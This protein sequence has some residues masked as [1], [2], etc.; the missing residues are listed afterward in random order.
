MNTS[1]PEMCLSRNIYPEF[2]TIWFMLAQIQI[3]LGELI[4]VETFETEAAF[5]ESVAQNVAGQMT[6]AHSNQATLSL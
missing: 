4:V 6:S 1:A 5:L 2:P 3:Q